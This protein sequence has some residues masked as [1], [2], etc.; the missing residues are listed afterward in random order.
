MKQVSS[1]DIVN[2]FPAALLQN[3]FTGEFHVDHATRL[4]NFSD[5]RI[6]E[7]L[8]LAVAEP[9]NEQ[10]IQRLWQQINN[11]PFKD[12]YFCVRGGDRVLMVT[13]QFCAANKKPQ[14]A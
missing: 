8:P 10:A 9:R 13:P 6:Y 12:L 5:D 11:E 14:P 2:L 7:V 3:G 4:V 1:T